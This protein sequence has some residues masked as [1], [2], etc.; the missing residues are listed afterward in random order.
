[1]CVSAALPTSKL[2]WRSFKTSALKTLTSQ[3][4]C[5]CSPD[6]VVFT[7]GFVTKKLGKWATTC[8][9]LSSSTATLELEMK[10]Q[11][12]SSSTTLCT[13]D[14]RKPTNTSR[15]NSLRL[16][17]VITTCSRSRLIERKCSDLSQ[18]LLT[19]AMTWKA[20]CLWFGTTKFKR[21]QTS[22]LMSFGKHFRNS[23][24]TK[25]LPKR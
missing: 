4:C 5:G 19:L 3:T 7:L 14:L 22:S 11:I 21:T 25:R 1:M 13:Q 8:V 20:R 6:D 24:T 10:T 17:F 2:P 16:S 9:Q 18:E 12:D 15:L 23:I